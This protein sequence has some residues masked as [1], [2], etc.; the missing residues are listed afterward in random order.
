MPPTE[1]QIVNKNILV[2]IQSFGV[3]SHESLIFSHENISKKC[4]TYFIP[5]FII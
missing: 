5:W 4:D 2:S 3:I 1:T